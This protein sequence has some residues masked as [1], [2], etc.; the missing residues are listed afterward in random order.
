MLWFCKSKKTMMSVA[1]CHS[2]IFKT[3][4]LSYESLS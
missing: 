1:R 2:A 4:Y 3:I